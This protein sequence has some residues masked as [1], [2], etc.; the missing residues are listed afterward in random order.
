MLTKGLLLSV[1]LL[2]SVFPAHLRTS[3]D[4]YKPLDSFPFLSKTQRIQDFLEIFI[5]KSNPR[6]YIEDRDC[7]Q[8]LAKAIPRMALSTGRTWEEITA[9]A[10][11][12]SRF[13]CH[14]KHNWDTSYGHSYGPWQVNEIWNVTLDC[15]IRVRYWEVD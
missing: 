10:W 5:K 12:E 13:D 8:D 2:T 3:I 14:A 4:P 15:D 6:L 11:K 7:I 1:M 9:L